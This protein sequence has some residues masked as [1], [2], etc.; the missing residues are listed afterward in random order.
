M[1]CH[2]DNGDANYVRIFDLGK[3]CFQKEAE[4]FCAKKRFAAFAL[5]RWL[6]LQC[7]NKEKMSEFLKKMPK[8]NLKSPILI[9]FATKLAHHYLIFKFIET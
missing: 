6:M 9:T 3:S 8:S 5:E 7:G 4:I 2:C 1:K